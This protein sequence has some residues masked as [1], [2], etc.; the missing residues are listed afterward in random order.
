MGAYVL[1][2]STSESQNSGANQSTVYVTGTLYTGG[3]SY[4]GYAPSWGVYIGGML[5]ASGGGPGSMWD[6]AEFSFSG[7]YTFTHDAN[8]Y[9]GAV[10]TSVNFNG[11]GGYAPGDMWT[12]GTTYG[13]IDYDRRPATAGTVTAVVNTDK[14]V[15]VSVAATSSPAG[16]PT[17]FFAYSSDNGATWSAASAGSTTYAGGTSYTGY[18]LF[19]GL[20]PGKTYRFRVYA[21]NSDGTGGTTTM[22]TGVFINSGGNRWTGSN[23]TPVTTF[24]RWD[25]SNWVNVTTAKRWN[26]SSWVNL[27]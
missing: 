27:S 21:T 12:G 17:F 5:V 4:S 7:S 11:G 26:G 13:A 18:S 10:G 14:T 6:P 23:W 24:K 9:R 19:T 8:G 25:G 22:A 3:K 16:T 15:A 1:G 2:I 20:P